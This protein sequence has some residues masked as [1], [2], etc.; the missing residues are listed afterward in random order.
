MFILFCSNGYPN[1]SERFM[2]CLDISPTIP[3]HS[4]VFNPI[5]RNKKKILLHPIINTFIMMK[6]NCYVIIFIGIMI[7]KFIFA[8][9]LSSLALMD[10]KNLN[11]SNAI[12][13]PDDQE[14][15]Q[16]DYLFWIVY[17]S[18]IGRTRCQTPSTP[19]LRSV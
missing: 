19:I 11:D 6:Y 7:I 12:I 14:I 9:L 4:D 10:L 3:L 1:N 2:L 15:E 17:I 13:A 5:T 18:T 16:Q 8:V